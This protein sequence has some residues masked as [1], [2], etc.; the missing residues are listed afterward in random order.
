MKFFI[1]LYLAFAFIVFTICAGATNADEGQ[2]SASSRLS[3]GVN[4]AGLGYNY[5]GLDIEVQLG[6]SNYDVEQD[7]K[8]A[9]FRNV[10]VGYIFDVGV[11]SITPQISKS[12]VIAVGSNTGDDT[13]TGVGLSYRLGRFVIGGVKYINDEAGLTDFVYVG[14]RHDL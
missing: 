9:I 14:V 5:N 13:E 3:A 4:S 8:Q 12:S 1:P 10:S 6:V 2:F 7:T 11:G